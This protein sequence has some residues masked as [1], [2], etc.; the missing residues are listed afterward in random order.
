MDKS[1]KS[2]LKNIFNISYFDKYVDDKESKV[3][4]S[5][6]A[7]YDG[8]GISSKL[9]FVKFIVHIESDGFLTVSISDEYGDKD[10][11]ESEYTNDQIEMF[12]YEIIQNCVTGSDLRN[13]KYRPGYNANDEEI[14]PY[15][16]NGKMI[17]NISRAVKG[18]SLEDVIEY[19]KM[20]N[21]SP[22]FNGNK[23][24]SPLNKITTSTSS[25]DSTIKSK[26][27]DLFGTKNQKVVDLSGDNTET[28]LDGEKV[29]EEP[30]VI[31]EFTPKRKFLSFVSAVNSSR[32]RLTRNTAFLKGD[33]I[34]GVLDGVV[35]K[36][37]ICDEGTINFEEVDT[38]QVDKSMIERLINQIDEI[39]A[40]GY[41][42]KFVVKDLEFYDVD[43]IRCYLEVDHQK[44]IDKLASLIDSFKEEESKYKEES[45]LSD[46]GASILDALFSSD[47]REK[48]ENTKG[49][50]MD[51]TQKDVEVLLEEV[52]NDTKP[53]EVLKSA[54]ETYLEESFRK[55]NEDKIN[56]LSKRIETNHK[57]ISRVKSEVKQSEAKLN[58]LIE[59]T[60]V[61]ET[62]LSSFKVKDEPLGYVF[63]VS[64]EQKP[65]DIGLSEENRVIADKIGDI[66]NLKKDMLFKMLTDGYY[67]I[68]ISEKDNI[69]ADNIDIPK[70]VLEKL[71]TIDLSMDAKI[72]MV[73]D[74]TFEYRGSLNWHQL[75]DVMIKKGFEQDPEFDKLCN[76][77]SYDSKWKPEEPVIEEES[78]V[79]EVE[80]K[81]DVDNEKQFY[82]EK[83]S[84]Y[85]EP[86]DLV[87][88]GSM[89]FD[90]C[91]FSI[92]DDESSFDVFI[93]GKEYKGSRRFVST[94]GFVSIIELKDYGKWCKEVEDE[95][96]EL[97]DGV[98]EGFILPNFKG[99]IQVGGVNDDGEYLRN[100]DFSDYIQHQGEGYN[101]V[102]MNLPYGTEIV[103]LNS[104]MTLPTSIL[105]DRKIDKVID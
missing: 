87:V 11:I 81:V 79:E 28:Y 16:E 92:T 49:D 44:P 34:S 62:R 100:I 91:D 37:T 104:D 88:V 65:E 29:E 26:I 70:E 25:V 46:R 103:E 75:V 85:K 51:L 17:E 9:E 60:G 40:T 31:G 77:N 19:Y 21:K 71:K 23:S 7:C 66:L 95:G 55:M 82:A 4:K 76:S 48:L 24:Q 96:Y 98:I 58:K 94:Y 8:Y 41:A 18:V 12:F 5:K 6:T 101:S 20:N 56:E 80:S 73:G 10:F 90:S 43:K 32:V 3:Q 30:K 50:G 33:N 63:N 84:S 42:Q 52:E 27:N 59:D 39:E 15:D 68:K 105:R 93:G 78:K 53:N 61:L 86:T 45:T 89:A 99:E 64:E 2:V 69:N 74:G 38:N 54:A 36:I 72:K 22:K 67:T 47:D 1:I 57:E 35:F 13:V 97:S 102:F 83:I 14:Y